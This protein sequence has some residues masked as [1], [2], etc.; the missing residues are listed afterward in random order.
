MSTICRYSVTNPDFLQTENILENYILDYN[1][2]FA[3][4]LFIC[5]WKLHF[6]D[7]IVSFKSNTWYSVSAGYC[8]RNFL[9]S[10]I[11]YFE[12]YGR[13]F[14]HM[15]ELN[16]TFISDLKNMTFELYLNQPKSMLE[17]KLNVILAKNP[18]LKKILGNSSHPLVRKNQHFIED[19]GDN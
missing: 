11:K 13:K 5:K 16:I 18:E 3:F 1:K 17:W 9:L 14:S 4:Y 10:K 15:S 6:P 19:D 12:R 8:L 7:T 2:K